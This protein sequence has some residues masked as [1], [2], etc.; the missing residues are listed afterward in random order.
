[1]PSAPPDRFFASSATVS[2][3]VLSLMLGAQVAPSQVATRGLRTDLSSTA[4]RFL[5]LD[6]NGDGKADMLYYRP[7]NGYAGAYLSHGDGTFRYVTYTNAGTPESGFTGDLESPADQFVALDVNGDGKSDL[8]E[9]RPGS[10][11]T[12]LCLS[13]GDGTLKCS[14]LSTPSG[15]TQNSGFVD[16]MMNGT[17]RI[18]ALD[19][20]GDGKSDFIL[21]ARKNN[22]SYG[23]ARAYISK[24]DG[25]FTALTYAVNGQA[26]NGF[27]DN[28]SN[29]DENFVAMDL[30]GDGKS[31]FLFSSPS[32]GVVRAFISD[33]VGAGSINSVTTY[34]DDTGDHNGFVGN[35]NDGAGRALALDFNGDGKSDFLWYEPGQHFAAV[36]IS[37]AQGVT[38]VVATLSPYFLYYNGQKNGF[39][40]DLSSGADTAI[41]LDFNGDGKADFLFYR[42]GSGYATMYVSNGTA[43]SLNAFDYVNSGQTGFGFQGD[44]SSTY[45][46]A[47][48]LN[49]LGQANSG[50]LW[51]RPSGGVA[52]IYAY[53]QDPTNAEG[54]LQPFSFHAY[55]GTFLSDMSW[56]LANT[57]LKGIVMAGTHDAAMYPYAGP[58]N[59]D[60]TQ[61]QSFSQQ[62]ADGA[63]A[64]DFRFAYFF[65]DPSD[66]YMATFIGTSGPSSCL[67]FNSIATQDFWLYGHSST[68][69]ELRMQDELASIAAFLNNNPYEIVIVNARGYLS[70][71]QGNFTST[72][73][74]ELQSVFSNSSGVQLYSP[75]S[76]CGALTCTST[77]VQPQNVTPAQ[78]W[79][80]N[81][82]L[83]LLDDTGNDGG[84]LFPTGYAWDQTK[85]MT[86]VGYCT[87]SNGLNSG[88]EA[89][90]E[91]ELKCVEIGDQVDSPGYKNGIQTER[92]YFQPADASST[93]LYASTAVTPAGNGDLGSTPAFLLASPYNN[94]TCGDPDAFLPYCTGGAINTNVFMTQQ[95][96]NARW[97]ANSLNM[98]A[99]DG[100][101]PSDNYVNAIIGQN[102]QTWVNRQFQPLTGAGALAA[103]ANGDVWVAPKTGGHGE[104][105]YK[106]NPSAHDWQLAIGGLANVTRLAVDPA[107][108]VWVIQSSGGSYQLSH[109]D[110]NGHALTT[111]PVASGV[112][113]ISVGTNGSI[114]A[115]DT[116]G[117][118]LYYANSG[119]PVS[120]FS[121]DNGIVAHCAVTNNG[122]LLSVNTDGTLHEINPT[123]LTG[124]A[125]PAIP[126]STISLEEGRD[127]GNDS[128]FLVL[129]YGWK[130]TDISAGPDGSIFVTAIQSGNEVVV[131][132]PPS[133]VFYSVW[134]FNPT[135]NNWDPFRM[136]ATHVSAGSGGQPWA[137][138]EITGAVYQGA[139]DQ[140]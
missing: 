88:G 100:I 77:A 98:F 30:N 59:V 31:D 27:L 38:N 135:T 117:Q 20:N 110:K 128:S 29:N 137:I 102:N 67:A 64:F 101:L 83:I 86:S 90:P 96:N 9:Y 105:L 17:E 42:P 43:Q 14:T 74:S 109:Y 87:I 41:V 63:R 106:Y 129:S 97:S 91:D 39:Q 140:M 1:M 99:F 89:T 40:G 107:G 51:Y 72:F 18:I 2:T 112:T 57:P 139:L 50:F 23:T 22:G 36:F 19:L 73:V 35:A 75:L 93:F 37:Q 53:T 82:R 12:I 68:C 8:I 71:S 60:I 26:M 130:A 81:Q 32:H 46:T 78:L 62:L 111:S 10:G 24:G 113:D 47:I 76:A 13:N 66:E 127:Q 79:K 61:Q 56:S 15:D 132:V 3:I 16:S 69:A 95:M 44:A 116:A 131:T 28:L 45:D 52:G 115:V 123:A 136:D 80:S 122:N 108:T 119:T 21:W 114:C 4:D 58:A 84:S 104:G 133:N 11:Y 7:G 138:R 55:T 54:Y 65:P 126:N 48:A 120:A 124:Y 134:R 94:A 6:L 121:P 92:P 33:P 125:L 5:S 118:L 25:T 85:T 70:G 49:F 103:G 34:A